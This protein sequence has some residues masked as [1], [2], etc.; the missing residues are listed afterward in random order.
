MRGSCLGHRRVFIG[1]GELDTGDVT[2]FNN[3]K[4]DNGIVRTS[5]RHRRGESQSMTV[6]QSMEMGSDGIKQ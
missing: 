4:T 1:C 3:V 5:D 2:G 6:G